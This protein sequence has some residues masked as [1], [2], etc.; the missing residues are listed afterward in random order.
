MNKI[1]DS[2]KKKWNF[3]KC[4]S[5]CDNIFQIQI[6]I[7]ILLCWCSCCFN[8]SYENC[9]PIIMSK[10]LRGILKWKYNCF[11]TKQ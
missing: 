1:A 11:Q 5:L 4:A 8:I 7:I 9:N 10:T 3:E 6:T 2:D